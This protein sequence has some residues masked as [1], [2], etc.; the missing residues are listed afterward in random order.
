MSVPVDTP[1][2]RSP[3]EGVTH[4]E[5]DFFAHQSPTRGMYA[6]FGVKASDIQKG[7]RLSSMGG[8]QRIPTPWR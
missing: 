8:Q 5:S 1:A 7:S 6:R 2:M 3:S 4:S